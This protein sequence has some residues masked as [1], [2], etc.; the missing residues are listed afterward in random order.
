M[1][2]TVKPYPITHVKID[3]RSMIRTICQTTHRLPIVGC[4]DASAQNRRVLLGVSAVVYRILI[5][6]PSAGHLPF[7]FR[8]LVD[9]DGRRSRETYSF[10]VL[11]VAAKT[12]NG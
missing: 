7:Q 3:R 6:G 5:T 1:T 4:I 12:S 9:I 10:R 2:I 8:S 11:Q